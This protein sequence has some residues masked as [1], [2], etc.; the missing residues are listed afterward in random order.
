MYM[1]LV[2]MVVCRY[3]DIVPFARMEFYRLMCSDACSLCLRTIHKP[4]SPSLHMLHH[5]V[6]TCMY[7][8]VH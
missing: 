2:Y 5:I 3:F 4:V 8:C 6:L 1:Y 7:V